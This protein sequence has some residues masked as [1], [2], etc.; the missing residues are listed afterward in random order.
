MS[1]NVDFGSPGL[2]GINIFF[3]SKNETILFIEVV[4]PLPT[5]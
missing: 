3:P 2:F 5:L 1:A 4:L